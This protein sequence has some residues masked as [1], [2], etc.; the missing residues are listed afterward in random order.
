[1]KEY[2]SKKLISCTKEGLD[3]DDTEEE[4]K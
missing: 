3:L 2:E 1:M 4:K